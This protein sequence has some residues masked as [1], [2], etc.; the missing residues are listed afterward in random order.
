MRA[1]AETT[2]SKR[3]QL[4]ASADAL[5]HRQGFNRTTLADV[6]T[7][8]GVLLGNLYYYFKT[9]HDLGEAVVERRRAH[10]LRQRER[11]DGLERP[12]DRLVALVRSVA[13]ERESLAA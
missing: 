7:E 8:S 11:W 12:A 2:P 10:Y 9:K 5:A 6:A 1:Q 13:A 3:D 4:V